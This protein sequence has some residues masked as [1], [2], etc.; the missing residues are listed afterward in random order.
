LGFAHWNSSCVG[1]LGQGLMR[2]AIQH[3]TSSYD[4]RPLA[5]ANPFYRAGEKMPIRR[6]PR[7]IPDSVLE[8]L[9]GIVE[10]LSLN[11][12]WQGESDR[13]GLCLRGE[14]AHHF[15]KGS[16]ELVRPVDAVPISRDRLERIVY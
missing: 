8:Q 9:Y 13:S 2:L 3:S 10:R 15:W 5:R 16:H 4:E 7:N 12:L 1:E 11:V 14:D 6:G